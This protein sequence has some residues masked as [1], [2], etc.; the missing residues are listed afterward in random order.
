MGL[1]LGFIMKKGGEGL[2]CHMWSDL[3]LHAAT[4]GSNGLTLP[5]ELKFSKPLQAN[6]QEANRKGHFSCRGHFLKSFCLW[7]AVS[8]QS[9]I[10]P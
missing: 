9:G 2:Q 6:L 5:G 7:I 3:S 8:M 4:Q 1:I 10:S